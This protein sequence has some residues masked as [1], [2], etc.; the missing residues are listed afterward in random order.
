LGANFF[1][2]LNEFFL[3]F[4]QLSKLNI[5]KELLLLLFLTLQVGKHLVLGTL[6]DV[7]KAEVLSSLSRLV[8]KSRILFR[9]QVMQCQS[10]L[11]PFHCSKHKFAFNNTL[12]L[13]LQ[14]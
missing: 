11:Q 3:R 5:K 12:K 10:S 6:E 8:S 13:L 4:M 2:F 7:L 9:D 14:L 1:H